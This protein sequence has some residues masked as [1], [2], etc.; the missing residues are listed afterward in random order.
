MTA[1]KVIFMGAP[2]FAV[3]S[4]QT[5]INSEHE[6]VAVYSQPPRPAGRGK[7]ERPTPVHQLAETHNIPVF[8]PK[9][10]KSEDIQAQFKAHSADLAIVVAY[11]LILPQAILNA[12]PMGCMNVHPSHLP[13]WR[14]AA[15][16]QRT[17]MAGDCE[18]SCMIMQMDAGLDTG[19]ILHGRDY[20]IRSRTTAGDLHDELS[21]DAGELL[22]EAIAGL[23][24]GSIEPLAQPKQG[25]TYAE[26]ISKD[27][28]PI[29]FNWSAEKLHHHIMG[30]SPY[31]GATFEIN[32][33]IIKILR[34]EIA[35]TL[36]FARAGTVLSDKL[37]I[38]CAEGSVIRLTELQRAGKKPMQ[39]EDFLRGF[40]IKKGES[41]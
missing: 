21:A 19:D 3:P 1:L 37:A 17:I 31:P 10:L 16:I 40:P 2:E 20:D 4:L 36:S 22:L 7:K 5:L 9:S 39:A 33:E 25:E 18:T 15:P 8:T 11:G 26:K 30:M 28:R 24:D 32:G 35:D 29:D 13:R 23:Q 27:E 14:G 6:V 41:V 34:S 38:A 12:C